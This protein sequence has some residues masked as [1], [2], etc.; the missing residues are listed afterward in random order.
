MVDAPYLRSA[1]VPCGGEGAEVMDTADNR[2]H[3]IEDSQPGHTAE[4]P[5]IPGFMSG[6]NLSVIKTVFVLPFQGIPPG[7][8]ITGNFGALQDT[9]VSGE[10]GIQSLPEF[11]TGNTG[12][13]GKK[14]TDLPPRMNP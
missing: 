2:S 8:K 9:N 10:T 11:L 5:G 3:I 7:M 6:Q 12:H 4:L 14:I 1:A 13:S